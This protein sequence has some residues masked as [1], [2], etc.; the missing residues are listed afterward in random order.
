[1][2]AHGRISPCRARR[3]VWYHLAMRH[4]ALSACLLAI[5]TSCGSGPADSASVDP[6]VA[7]GFRVQ[8]GVA[9]SF[10]VDDCEGLARCFG[11]NVGTPYLLFSVPPH[12]DHPAALPPSMVGDVPR[13][14][15]GMSASYHL[16]PGEV[17]V[18]RGRTPPP[19]RYYGFTPYLFTRV[20]GEGNRVTTFAS[21][22]DTINH[23]VVDDA[24]RAS[25]SS[26]IA[27]V[28]SSDLDAIA[29]AET[30]LVATGTDPD[31]IF[32]MP[33]RREG[34]RYGHDNDADSFLLLGRM[35]LV[36]DPAAEASYVEA[37][38]LE[39]LRLTPEE[40]GAAAGMPE[41]LPRGD[42]STEAHL[43]PALDALG[44]ALLAS[45]DGAEVDVIDITS[46]DLI[47]RVIEPE[48]CIEGAKE[49]LG[50]NSDTTY[51]VGPL[52]VARGDDTLTLGADDTLWVY[53][54]DHAAAEKATYASMSVYTQT[55]RVGVLSFDSVG[56][57]GTAH[58]F[59]PE[60]P[61]ADRLWVQRIR[62]DCGGAAGCLELGTDFPGVAL[63]ESLFLIFR[64]Y[65]NPG[66]TVSPAHGEILTERAFIVRG[67]P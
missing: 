42:G 37:P 20:D 21:L 25:F 63:E 49:C 59:L 13:V 9:T 53:G 58:A 36:D 16:D 12:P 27:L 10:I 66:M 28:M 24:G 41:R 18:V 32:P 61:E 56:M 31:A 52:G 39:V 22:S 46:S 34:L 62:R 29:A 23:A 50:D 54:V 65:L 57:A 2:H 60:H 26:E 30:A 45:V 14:P 67:G 33:I 64:A 15:E 7:G 17:I 44:A 11:N 35:A 8:T 38:P 19:A 47:A 40:T 6:F 4:I 51:A 5:S 55:G 1:M 48:A 43:S 3:P